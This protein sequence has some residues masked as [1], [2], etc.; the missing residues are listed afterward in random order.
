[1]HHC[2]CMYI[3]KIIQNFSFRDRTDKWLSFLLAV[4]KEHIFC[5]A[6][7]VLIPSTVYFECKMDV[8]H[9]RHMLKQVV[10]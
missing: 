4:M 3:Y 6:G 10:C 9:C 2:V 1:M 7:A 8:F 5:R